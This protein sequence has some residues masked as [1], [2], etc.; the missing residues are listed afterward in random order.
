MKKICF[1]YS[2]GEY[3]GSEFSAPLPNES[4]AIAADDGLSKMLE[5][6]LSPDL[7]VGDFDSLGYVPKLSNIVKLPSEKDFSDTAVAI[8]EGQDRGF[9]TFII[10]GG[11]GGRIDHSISNIQSLYSLCDRGESGYLIGDGTIIT[12][13]KNSSIEF[14]KELCGTIS[15]FASGRADG[16]SINGLKYELSDFTLESTSPIGLSNEFKGEKANISVKNGTLLIIWN[17]DPAKLIARL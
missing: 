17:E 9:C 5:N 11:L 4:F 1:I 6:D 14:P 8:K 15:V 3:Y 7:V 13:I 2:A 10:Y 12:A 16:V